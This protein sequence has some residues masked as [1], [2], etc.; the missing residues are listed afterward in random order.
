MKNCIVIILFFIFLLVICKTFAGTT[1][2]TSYYPPP[3][4]DYNKVVLATNYTSSTV[5]TA[6]NCKDTTTLFV[7]STTGILQKCTGFGTSTP[8]C[9]LANTTG[10]VVA[11]TQGI[12]HA[13]IQDPKTGTAQSVTYPQECYNYFCSY[14]NTKYAAPPNAN[15]PCNI[16][17]N[18]CKVG[19]NATYVDGKVPPDAYD[20]FNTASSTTVVSYLCCSGTPASYAVSSFP[21]NASETCS[22]NASG[23]SGSSSGSSNGASS[24]S[25]NGSSSGSHGASSSG[26]GS[27]SGSHSASSGSSGSGSGS[28]SSSGMSCPAGQTSCG[29]S[30]TGATTCCGSGILC[31]D[32]GYPNGT[33]GCSSVWFCNTCPSN[34]VPCPIGG[35][36]ICSAAGTSNGCCPVSCEG[37]GTCH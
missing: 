28:G 7:D 22:G 26:S 24:G 6:G 19:F 33:G 20:C 1:S 31:I 36:G 29:P 15:N 25:G 18:P 13:C 34:S 37:Q 8:Y 35:T 10:T 11:D 30:L 32:W 16:T 9:S 12:L 5:K 21:G 14:D 17:S 3:R 27:S 23:S 2:L 4:G